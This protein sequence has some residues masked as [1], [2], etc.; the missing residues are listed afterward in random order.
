MG[1][2]Q[3][4][5]LYFTDTGKHF[6]SIQ[7]F[8]LYTD[9]FNWKFPTGAIF[10]DIAK[11]FDSVWH[12]GLIYKLIKLNFPDHGIRLIV[13]YLQDRSFAVK[14]GNSVS[15]RRNIFAGVPQGSV[16]SPYLYNIYTCDI[17]EDSQITIALFADD[18]AV[19]IQASTATV[20][21]LF[22]QHYLNHLE[23]WL[24]SW[25]IAVNSE[26]SKAII[27]RKGQTNFTLPR[28]LLVDVEI[29]WV[30]EVK[31]LGV[32]LDKKLTF[33]KHRRETLKKINITLATMRPLLD[34]RSHMSVS[35][36]LNSY[37]SILQPALLYAIPV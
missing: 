32:I 27:F 5:I 24:I 23:K 6:Y 9:G 19:M 14:I 25:K 29:D 15:T 28:P 1:R 34:R 33:Q 31:Y 7:I 37:K 26:K 16:L 3:E 8:K 11:A 36:K 22:L 17:P 13:S 10:L 35:N 12:R 4:N 2:W 30:D 18:T 20:V 21:Q